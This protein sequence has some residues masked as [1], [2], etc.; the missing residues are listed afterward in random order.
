MKCKELGL[1]ET[2]DLQCNG[3]Q[4]VY[5]R[6]RLTTKQYTELE[7]AR[8][9]SDR[10]SKNSLETAERVAELYL[11]MAQAYLENTETHAPITKEEFENMIWE[12]IRVVIDACHI[13]TLM[14]VPS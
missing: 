4:V 1:K 8:Q 13:R 6:K 12:E 5:K 2:Y 14:G 7:K 9:K 11:L 10:E 3:K